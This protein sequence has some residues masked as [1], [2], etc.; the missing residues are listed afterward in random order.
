MEFPET[1]FSYLTKIA[2]KDPDARRSAVE[3]VLE[4]EKISYTLQEDAASEK[5][6]RGIRNYI[7]HTGGESDLP[8]KGENL[9]CA[10]YDAVP[11]SYGANDNAAAVCI[12][13]ALYRKFREKNVSASFALFD[14]EESG[15][16]GAKLYRDIMKEGKVAVPALALNLDVCGYGDSIVICGKDHERKPAARPFVSKEVLKRHN[17]QLMHYLPESDDIILRR[18][19]IPSLSIA[20]VPRWDVQYL[21]ALGASGGG[22]L[23]RTPEFRMIEGE[24][25]VSTTMHGG[26]RDDPKWIQPKAMQHVFD[27]LADAQENPSAGTKF[28][29]FRRNVRRSTDGRNEKDGLQQYLQT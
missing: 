26:Y 8:K 5:F 7:F 27:Y 6:P 29:S 1:I 2:Q 3:D 28:W 12:L 25:E 23:G 16:E 18:A 19:G 9:F 13:L 15:H 10:H 4:K 11:G 17:A 22:L 24:M 14:L 20:I 21:R